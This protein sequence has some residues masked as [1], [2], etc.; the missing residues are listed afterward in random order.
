M[1]DALVEH[2]ELKQLGMVIGISIDRY[3]PIQKV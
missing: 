2:Q 1:S 3:R